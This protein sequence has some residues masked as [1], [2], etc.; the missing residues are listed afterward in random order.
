[1]KKL[2]L[3]FSVFVL[4]FTS[5]GNNDDD[6]PTLDQFIGTWKYFKH[7]ENGV[8]ETLDLCETEFTLQVLE[9]G[10]FI[11]TYYMEGPNNTCVVDETFTTTW[12]NEGGGN[13]SFDFD[14]DVEIIPIT[15]ENNTFY[16]QETYN[17]NTDDITTRDV[18]IRVN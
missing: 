7:F 16:I 10:T 6:T 14:G 1:M 5:C 17:D 11:E 15:F 18:F 9:D 8:E 13:Y 3:V 4:V 12:T 2:L